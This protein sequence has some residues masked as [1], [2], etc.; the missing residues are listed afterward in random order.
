MRPIARE[1]LLQR[2]ERPDKRMRLRESP[3]LD[4]HRTFEVACIR[5]GGRLNLKSRG[6]GTDVSERH[7][8]E[9]QRLRR[10]APGGL[11]RCR[12]HRRE[13]FSPG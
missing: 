9:L 13:E 2:R 3:A 12:P 7:A 4:V 1:M 5:V 10:I 11:G 8:R 6:I